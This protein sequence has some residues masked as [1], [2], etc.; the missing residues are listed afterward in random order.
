V[1][2]YGLEQRGLLSRVAA[3]GARPAVMIHDLIPILHPEYCSPSAAAWHSARIMA[4]LEHQAKVI[5]NSAATASDL[6]TFA[7]AIGHAAPATIVAPLGIETAFHACPPSTGAPEP[8]A[9]PYFVCVGTLEPRK[10][11]TFLLTLWRRLAET[12]G[13]DTPFL[14][15]AGRR[16]WET[17]AILDHL[18]RSPPIR[19]FVHEVSGLDDGAL[20]MLLS[21]ARALLSASVI[22]GFDLPVAEALAMATPVIASDIAA[23]RELAPE[24]QLLDPLDGPAWFATILAAAKA[25]PAA[26]HRPAPTWA[27]HFA[28]VE[29]ALGLARSD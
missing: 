12:L 2:H 29:A 28:T 5:V 10:N 1:S 19:R 27:A 4:I 6:N 26:R 21:G 13:E 14:V 7:E 25:R 18:D 3:L 8:P 16:G 9:R 15:L 20:S 11:L 23:H 22:E 17:E 24:A